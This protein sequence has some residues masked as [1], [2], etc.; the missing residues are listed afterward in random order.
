MD[1]AVMAWYGMASYADAKKPA[2]ARAAPISCSFVLL[3]KART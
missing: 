1:T 2:S 3:G